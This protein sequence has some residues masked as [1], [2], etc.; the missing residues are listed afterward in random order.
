M[1]RVSTTT[2]GGGEA[3]RRITDGTIRADTIRSRTIQANTIRAATQ[4]Q[5]IEESASPNRPALAAEGGRVRPL[6][7]EDSLRPRRTVTDGAIPVGSPVGFAEGIAVGQ[8]AGAPDTEA[9]RRQMVEVARNRGFLIGT[10]E[11]EDVGARYAQDAYVDLD[12][13][14]LYYWRPETEED[15]PRW[16]PLG[17][18]STEQIDV[19]IDVPAN[20]EYIITLRQTYPIQIVALWQPPSASYTITLS[21]PVESELEVGDSISVTLSGI[22]DGEEDEPPPPLA[23]SIETRRL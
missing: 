5:I 22:P 8:P 21:P 12:T 1:A 10:G 9:L 6:G 7:A 15:E 19:A 23:L 3:V 18:D 11:P 4:I 20:R 16:E 17:Q 2:F 13:G 14:Q